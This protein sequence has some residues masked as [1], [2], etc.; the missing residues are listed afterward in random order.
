MRSK[1]IAI[2][3]F[4]TILLLAATAIGCSAPDTGAEYVV[5]YAVSNGKTDKSDWFALSDGKW[6]N[7]VYESG[8]Y[9]I[10]D[11]NE[12]SFYDVKKQTVL[13]R[14]R[15]DK[16]IL[17]FQADGSTK[18]YYS[19]NFS[20]ERVISLKTVYTLATELG[21]SG[22]LEEL[23]N[24]FKGDSA[25]QIAVKNGYKG[26]E[27]EWLVSLVGASGITPSIK[28]EFWYVGDKPT[29][30][31][32]VGEKGD[33]GRGI[34]KIE[35]VSEDGNGGKYKIT[36]TDGST[37][38]FTVASGKDGKGIKNIEKTATVG[39]TDEYTITLTDGSFYT[40]NV[41]NG[42]NEPVALTAQQ[43]YEFMKSN[44][45]QGSY[46][47]F[48]LLFAETN[49]K[50]V[51]FI[52]KALLSSVSVSV[53]ELGNGSEGSGVI[54]QMDKTAGD[55]FVITNFHVVYKEKT[56]EGEPDYH[57][58]IKVYL[59]GS[60]IRANSQTAAQE[61]G[62]DAE[63]IGGSKKYDIAVLKITGSDAIKKTILTAAEFTDSD[64][65]YVGQNVI[66]VGNAEGD[67]ISVTD[68]TINLASENIAIKAIDS[69]DLVTRRVIR[70]S[71]A[72]NPGNSG[73]GVFDTDGKIIGITD[74]KLVAQKVDN[75]GYAI[76]SNV[77]KIV[78]DNIIAQHKEK[79]NEKHK[80][81]R[82]LMGMTIY[83]YSSIPEIDETTGGIS[84]RETVK[85]HEQAANA[86]CAGKVA[87]GDI[88]KS[89]KVGDGE[90]KEV[91]HVYTLTDE[92]MKA[93]IGD[94]I[95]FVLDRNGSE[96]VVSVT[97]TADAMEYAD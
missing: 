52:T 40:F 7:S 42:K 84:I 61:M 49:K 54:Y 39:Q 6:E 34:E 43:L 29:G 8:T 81:Y 71:A 33:A 79:P 4:L 72:I 92:V 20:E 2:I 93:K 12:I 90:K 57:T 69:D 80:L 21:Y 63:F 5:F 25:Y 38:S 87:A 18:F 89:I 78:A 30:I 1:K 70:V 65:A 9:S 27:T 91:K 74:A 44:G 46:Q 85:V 96:I 97:V 14:G 23:I 60:E 66:A 86:L 59:Y 73:G 68:G 55:A 19:E 45:Y 3:A 75:I 26:T 15:F 67:G 51:K 50:D 24:A 32:A 31:R 16:D 11:K 36:Y 48:A 76:P 94:N 82:P 28:D 41:T 62:I 58:K 17:S 77:A 53:G 88:I 83:V 47:D 10:N 13:Y 56:T 64:K 95:E 37:Y 35:D 22:T